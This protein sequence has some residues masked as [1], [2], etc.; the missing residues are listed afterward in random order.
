MWCDQ[1]PG[2][3]DSF[4]SPTMIGNAEL[5]PDKLVKLG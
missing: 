1:D 4:V 5:L 3:V 2:L